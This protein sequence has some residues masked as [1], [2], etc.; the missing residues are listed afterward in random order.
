[1]AETVNAEN[2]KPSYME[3]ASLQRRGVVGV[4]GGNS[5][6]NPEDNIFEVVIP[7]SF[8]SSD[9]VVL[10][11]DVEGV[12]GSTGVALSINDRTAMGVWWHTRRTNVRR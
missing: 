6:D 9:K 8:S 5:I 1:M 10:S 7:S 11:Y 12:A 2:V 4:Y 3:Y